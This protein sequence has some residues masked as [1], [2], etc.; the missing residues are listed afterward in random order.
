MYN[1]TKKR[2]KDKLFSIIIPVAKETY[3]AD[4]IQSVVT[5]NDNGFN[6]EL[7]IV[8]DTN[9]DIITE[10][11][12]NFKNRYP[13]IDIKYFINKKNSG[14]H[15]PTNT[16]NQGLNYATGDYTILLG[17]DD[18]LGKGYLKEVRKVI[19]I[20]PKATLIRTKL[21]EIDENGNPIKLG[22]NNVLEE[23]WVEYIYYR[24]KYLRPQSTSEFIA[25]TE[26]LK[27]IGGYVKYPNAWGSDDATWISLA[28]KSK[29]VIS[30]NEVV[31]CWR[32]HP[33]SI[34]M[35]KITKKMLITLL[36]LLKWE[37]SLLLEEK[38]NI[39]SSLI[40]NMGLQSIKERSEKIVKHM[41]NS[42][43]HCIFIK[44]LLRK[45]KVL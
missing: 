14:K 15:Y 8:N 21:L 34:S 37:E 41:A 44:K 27:S 28:R 43:A 3:L 35:N 38:K 26:V 6:P 36:D 31:A 13:L 40:F 25:K 32:R 42:E 1:E 20:F 2:M 29:F 12:Q 5:Q 45:I 9:S 19:K 30:T 33:E 17:D 11:V 10:I 7:I 24:N 16:W 23:S 18:L 22:W 39:K 4:A